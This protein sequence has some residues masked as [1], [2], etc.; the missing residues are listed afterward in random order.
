MTSAPFAALLLGGV[1]IALGQSRE[2][3]ETKL[4]GLRGGIILE[5]SKKHP[6]DAQLAATPPYLLVEYQ[7][8]DGRVAID[9]GVYG[10]PETF[11]IDKAGIVRMKHVG[12]ITPSV[13]SERSISR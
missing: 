5:W 8:S 1:S 4:T 13:L 2:T 3:L 11:V 9:W 6:W 10:V 12:P 7:T